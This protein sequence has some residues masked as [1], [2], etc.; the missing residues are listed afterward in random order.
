MEFVPVQADAARLAQYEALFAAC[1]PP[2]ARL[3]ADYL[4]WLYSDNPDG[5]IVGFD[6]REGSKV[7]AHVAFVPASLRLQG[8]Q[9]HGLL[10]LNIATHP[11]CQGRGL[12]TQLVRLTI[13]SLVG[14]HFSCIFGVANSNALPGWIGRLGFQDVCGLDA[15]V[16]LGAGPSIDHLTANAAADFAR[17]WT[18]ASL[19]WRCANP[20][21]R[22]H[23]QPLGPDL[24]RISARTSYPLIGASTTLPRPLGFELAEAGTRPFGLLN[25]HLGLEPAGTSTRS[26]SM[27]IPERVK[28][29]PLRLIYRN[30]VDP[31]D[32]LDPAR[33]LFR[34]IDFDAY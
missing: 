15:I 30:L 18:S 29:S 1:F 26:L 34:M 17:T 31:G 9:T 20:K 14:S 4:T 27:P 16:G 23:V 12:F 5:P 24:V 2:S 8:Q 25:L 22:L 3:D 33:I 19:T 6:A 13:D 10:A 7:I 21:N 28:P 11:H 32:H